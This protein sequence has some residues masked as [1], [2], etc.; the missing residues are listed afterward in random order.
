MYLSQNVIRIWQSKGRQ[1]ILPAPLARYYK[2]NIRC[3]KV[4]TKKSVIQK[5]RHAMSWKIMIKISNSYSEK[6]GLKFQGE[7]NFLCLHPPE[8]V[9]LSGAL[10]WLNLAEF[11]AL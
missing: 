1:Q 9:I 11:Q 4:D 7:T 6:D 10:E 5:I 3:N 8:K 2:S